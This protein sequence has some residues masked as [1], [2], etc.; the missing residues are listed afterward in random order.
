MFQQLTAFILATILIASSASLAA[1]ETLTLATYNIEYFHAHFAPG[2]RETG[3]KELTERLRADADKDN[4]IISTVILDPKF[5]PDAMVIEECCEQDELEKF[6]KNWLK[7]A[8][9]TVIVFPNNSDRHQN[10]GMLLKPGFKVLEKRDQYY[11]EKDTAGGNERGD[12]LFA[13]GPSFCKIQSPGGYVFWMGVTHQKSKHGNSAEVTQW[14]NREARRTHQII[15]EL[16]KAG[17]GD[18]VLLGDMND[19]YGIQEFELDGGGDSI[20]NLVG[21]EKDGCTLLTKPLIEAGKISYGGYWKSDYRSFID[22][23]IVTQSMKPLVKE[24]DVF[25]NA[26]APAA[27]DHFPVYVKIATGKQ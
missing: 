5:F 17:P 14:R 4:W 25:K 6:N 9:E 8:Y 20:A 19:E 7:N 13:R 12:K 23:I 24:V 26:M 1:D 21:P 18:V 22:Q 16:E 11:Q 10:L 3:D 27:S 2:V 15:K